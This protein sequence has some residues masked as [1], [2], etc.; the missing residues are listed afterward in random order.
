MVIFVIII[1][2]YLLILSIDYLY[3]VINKRDDVSMKKIALSLVFSSILLLLNASVITKWDFE[4]QSL[5]PSIG[6]GS[7][8]LLGGVTNGGFTGG[9][10]S[11]YAFDTLNYPA[12]STNNLTAGIYFEVST[13]GYTNILLSWSQ[14]HSNT[15][16]N[17]AVL[18]YTLDKTASSPVWVLANTYD[19]TSGDTWFQRTFDGSAIRRMASNPNLAFKLVSCFADTSNTAYVASRPASSYAPSGKWRFDNISIDGIAL[20]PIVQIVSNFTPF[21]AN[22]NAVSTVQNYTVSGYN[23]TSDLLITPPEC[24]EVRLQEVGSFSNSLTVTPTLGSINAVI[25]VRYHPTI[26]ENHSG[27]ISHSGNDITTQNLAVSGTTT[28]PE[29]SSHTTDLTA[30]GITYYQLYLNWNDS[31]GEV[32]P[33]GYI[34]KGSKISPDS[35]SSPVDGVVEDTKKLTK[36][37]NYGVQTILLYGLE[38]NHPYYF[39]IFP[40]TNSGIM[41]DYKT[42]GMIP[43]LVVNTTI[44]TIGSILNVG[45]IA[46]LEYATDSPDRFSF[47]LLRDIAENTK[48]N[49]TDKAWDGDFL[50]PGEDIYYWRGVGRSYSKG[51]VIHIEE[52]IPHANEGVVDPDLSGFSNNGDQI[53]AFQ[54]D[55]DFPV[56]IAGFSTTGWIT[57]GIPTTN[58]SYLPEPLIQAE[59]ALGFAAEIDNGCY[60][61]LITSGSQALIRGAINNPENW[62]RSNSLP[63]ITFPTW[64]I[65]VQYD[66]VTNISVQKLDELTLRISWTGPVGVISFNLYRSLDSYATFPGSWE[67]IQSGITEEHVDVSFDS[68]GLR[69]FYRIAAVY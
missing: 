20:T 16:A 40:Y 5:S 61:G 55:P 9:Y 21:F 53:L 8:S 37:V 35:I 19:A 47:V 69:A 24:F 34:I 48:I 36:Y 6:A 67:L 10:L 12:Q 52:G 57:E 59:T 32:L 27:Y 60:N 51:E 11:T 30:S 68:R 14:R 43:S 49:F 56:F 45:D 42:D 65:I 41:I 44:G 33:D 46:F 7:L 25:E 26:P 29:P 64:N 18:Y 1:L 3:H 66:G 62:T 50:M 22:L 54:G 38:E 58:S 63:N 4:T 17:R 28:I 31:Q 39:K 15:S 23:L 2:S 13:I